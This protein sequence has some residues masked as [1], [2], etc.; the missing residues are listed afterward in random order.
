MI[1]KGSSNVLSIPRSAF[2]ISLDIHGT[3]E[4]ESM[5]AQSIRGIPNLWHSEKFF[6]VPD[7][8]TSAY[9]FSL[10]PIVTANPTAKRSS[11]DRIDLIR[12]ALGSGDEDLHI[13]AGKLPPLWTT[14]KIVRYNK[15]GLRMLHIDHTSI[16][17][18]PHPPL[19]QRPS[20]QN[21]FHYTHLW[22][23]STARYS[24]QYS[25]TIDWMTKKAGISNSG[26]ASSPASVQNGAT[27]YIDRPAVWICIFLSQVALV[28]LIYQRIYHPCRSSLIPG[29]RMSP[30]LT[31]TYFTQSSNM[32]TYAMLPSRL[33]RRPWTS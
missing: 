18:R 7:S 23:R 27:L 32:I 4:G 16:R 1:F 30:G 31:P 6:V 19:R 12:S 10:F 3:L 33:A 14:R 15:S 28:R 13:Y 17:Y 2:N 21:T 25:T 5:V 29:V 24:L 26:G 20:D 22:M 8:S 9:D 11:Q